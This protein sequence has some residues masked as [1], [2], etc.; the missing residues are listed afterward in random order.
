[1]LH[2]YPLPIKTCCIF[3]F[4][5]A[6]I[7]F[8]R[9]LVYT[10]EYIYVISNT[11][12]IK[13]KILYFNLPDSYDILFDLYN[14]LF[15]PLLFLSVIIPPFCPSYPNIT[16]NFTLNIPVGDFRCKTD[17]NIATH[18]NFFPFYSFKLLNNW[19]LETI[20]I[21]GRKCL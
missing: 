15:L 19:N 7:A 11:D 8:Y 13:L 4:L 20:L 17:N 12:Q 18:I 2:R 9:Y 21:S 3:F 5:N 6:M 16:L 14:V 1:M 10:L